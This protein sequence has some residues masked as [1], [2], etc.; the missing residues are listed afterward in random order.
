MRLRDLRTRYHSALLESVLTEKDRRIV[1]GKS[2][3]VMSNADGASEISVFL[4]AG[5]AARMGASSM[6]APVAGST[7]GSAFETATL[8][9]VREALSALEPLT[10]RLVVDRG[11]LI[12]RFEQYTHLDEIKAIVSSNVVLESAIGGDY[13]VRPDIV[14]SREPVPEAETSR[15]FD[16]LGEGNLA[17]YTPR[18]AAN[19]QTPELHASISCKWTIRSDRSQNTRT[20]ALNLSRN[21][22]GRSPHIVAVTM[23]PLPGRLASIAIGTGDIDCVYHGALNELVEAAREGARTLGG[24]YAAAADRLDVLIRGRRLRDIADLPFDLAD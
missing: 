9:F 19:N 21:R 22:K 1:G 5:A 17:R 18:R 16:D 15:L 12:S 2:M 23:E 11:R 6:R 13:L 20:E 24:G 7:S 3:P 14:V 10:G 8:A 4:A